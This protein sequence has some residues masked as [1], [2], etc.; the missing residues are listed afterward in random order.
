MQNDDFSLIAQL[1]YM[2]GRGADT[3]GEYG[4]RYFDASLLPD[5]E[6]IY[7]FGSW[8][9]L[10]EHKRMIGNL[11]A[12]FAFTHHALTS[13]LIDIDGDVATSEFKVVAGHGVMVDRQMRVI[14]GGAI[15]RQDCLR[16]EAGWRVR[17]H[18]CENS[19]VDDPAGLMARAMESLDQN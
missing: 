11:Q 15:Y 9:G 12:A 5:V 10:D 7:D 13:P 18:I 8:R 2:Y 4:H 3:I 19:W 6:V 17:R 16:T 14:W 1:G